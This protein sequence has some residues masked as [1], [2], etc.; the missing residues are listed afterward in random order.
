[1]DVI[2]SRTRLAGPHAI[3]QYR[4]LVPLDDVAALGARDAL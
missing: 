2:V 3:Y 4:A 1:M